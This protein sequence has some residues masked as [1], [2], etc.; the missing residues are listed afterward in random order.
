[1]Q[2]SFGEVAFVA[3]A[4]CMASDSFYCSFPSPARGGD[5]DGLSSG[6]SNWLPNGW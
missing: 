1:M 4:R 5:E 6:P 3:S 2:V